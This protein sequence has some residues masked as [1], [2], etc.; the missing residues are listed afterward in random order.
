MLI[1]APEKAKPAISLL[2]ISHVIISTQTSFASVINTFMWELI[3]IAIGDDS[4]QEKLL[5]I[6]TRNVNKLSVFFQ[7]TDFCGNYGIVKLNLDVIDQQQIIY[8]KL[9]I[10]LAV[11]NS[12]NIVVVQRF[13]KFEV[14]W[15]LVLQN[16]YSPFI[17]QNMRYNLGY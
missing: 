5:H 8:K 11:I 2:V 4:A 1:M 15:D 6:L 17:Q 16:N 9:E 3:E 7:T 14:S 13:W 10:L 12:R